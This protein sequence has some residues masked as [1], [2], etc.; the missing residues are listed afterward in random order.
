MVL[1]MVNGIMQ[2][3]TSLSVTLFRFVNRLIIACTLGSFEYSRG[4][5]EEDWTM[6]GNAGLSVKINSR[7]SPDNFV[8]VH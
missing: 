8:V 5:G 2:L 4:K 7:V 1:V 3:T 6:N